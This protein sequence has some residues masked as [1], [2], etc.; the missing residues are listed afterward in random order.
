[1]WKTI[2]LRRVYHRFPQKP[3]QSVAPWHYR[4]EKGREGRNK[5]QNQAD[6]SRIFSIEQKQPTGPAG[7]QYHRQTVGRK[8][9]H[10]SAKSSYRTLFC[11]GRPT[12]RT[13][14]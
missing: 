9:E 3:R 2:L 11:V 13:A 12:T 7:D 10:G 6:H 14:A 4:I 5:K 8:A 1:M